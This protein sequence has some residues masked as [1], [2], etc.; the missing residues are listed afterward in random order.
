[1]KIS[2][3]LRHKLYTQTIIMTKTRRRIKYALTFKT[4]AASFNNVLPKKDVS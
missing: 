3:F 2:S 1:M 4:V